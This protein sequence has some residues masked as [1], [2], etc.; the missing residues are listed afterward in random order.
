M[1]NIPEIASFR[2][3]EEEGEISTTRMAKLD[4]ISDLSA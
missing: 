3:E 4:K 2:E 1:S